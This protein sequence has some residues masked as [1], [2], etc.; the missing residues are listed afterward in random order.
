MD[1]ESFFIPPCLGVGVGRSAN[2][3]ALLLV[4]DVNVRGSGSSKGDNDERREPDSTIV[5]S[6]ANFEA[7][8]R[9]RKDEIEGEDAIEFPGVSEA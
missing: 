5:F 2:R 7:E 8:S 4:S 3:E 9:R 1:P 6:I